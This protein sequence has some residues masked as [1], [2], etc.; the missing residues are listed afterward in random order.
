[1]VNYKF[2]QSINFF[3]S[4]IPLYLMLMVWFASS[5]K[6]TIVIE[7]IVFIQLIIGIIVQMLCTTIH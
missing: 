6:R 5:L 2:W 7:G 4:Q 1:M 3:S